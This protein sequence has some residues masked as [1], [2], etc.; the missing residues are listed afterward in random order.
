MHMTNEQAQRE[1]DELI[2]KNGFTLAGRTSDTGII[3]TL[4][5]LSFKRRIAG[6]AT[7]FA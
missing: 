7:D 2:T 6:F 5:C 1:F 3:I 4:F